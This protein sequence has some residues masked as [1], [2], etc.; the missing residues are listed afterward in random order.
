[1]EKGGKPVAKMNR[2]GRQT[3]TRGDEGDHYLGQ[4]ARSLGDKKRPD[5]MEPQV[6]L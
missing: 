2:R 4:T 6:G 3:T 1:V 5:E